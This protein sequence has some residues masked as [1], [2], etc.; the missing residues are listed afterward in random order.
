MYVSLAGD[1]SDC[2][3]TNLFFVE[4]AL[5]V[6]RSTIRASLPNLNLSAPVLKCGDLL[7]P[8]EY[9]NHLCKKETNNQHPP[10]PQPTP[11]KNRAS[12]CIPTM[13]LPFNYVVVSTCACV[14]PVGC[15][16]TQPSS[17]CLCRIFCCFLCLPIMNGVVKD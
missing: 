13:W 17:Y 10:H 7:D 3:C 14:W 11:K 1:T 2:G 12:N 8:A 15:L 9:L 6:Q 4:R 5:R 16:R